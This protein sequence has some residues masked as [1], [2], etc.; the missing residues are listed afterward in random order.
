VKVQGFIIPLDM[1]DKQKRFLL[2]AV[3]PHCSFCLPA[4]PDSVVEV[5]AKSAVRYG[6]EP[7]V[8]SGKFAVLKDDAAGLLYRLTDAELVEVAKL[9]PGAPASL[10]APPAA[11]PAAGAKV[12]PPAK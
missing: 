3:P 7:I 12:A 9:A 2:A 1:G 10:L 5:V 4:G 8:V 11:D 6:F